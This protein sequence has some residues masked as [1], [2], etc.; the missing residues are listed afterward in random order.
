[1]SLIDEFALSDAQK[2]LW[3]AQSLDAFGTAYRV[4][5][6][7]TI[8]GPMDR[9]RLAGALLALVQRHEV[10]R[11][12]FALTAG[13]PVQRIQAKANPAIE[14]V[15]LPG[16]WALGLFIAD[17]LA[18]PMDPAH[19]T[20]RCVIARCAPEY[21][22][23][24]LDLHHLICDGVSVGIL[25][26]E[27]Q[28]LYQGCT[29]PEVDYQYVDWS[30]WKASTPEDTEALVFWRERLAKLPPPAPLF[31]GA[32]GDVNRAHTILAHLPPSVW[33]GV[34]QAAQALNVTSFEWLLSV[35]ASYLSAA[36]GVSPLAV[37]VPWFNRER[38]EFQNTVGCF[39]DTAI[40]SLSPAT[41]LTFAQ[42]LPSLADGVRDHLT[43]AAV[44]W[45]K[46]NALWRDAWP[47]ALESPQPR[48]LF[49]LQ[50][51][52]PALDR[53]PGLT[54]SV[55][56]PDNG[57]AKYDLVV[58]VDL[59]PADGGAAQVRLE[60][61]E[62]ALDSTQAADILADLRAWWLC[63]SHDPQQTV[64]ELPRLWRPAPLGKQ[65]NSQNGDEQGLDAW[66][67]D[68][69][70]AST[71]LIQELCTHWALTLVLERAGPDDNFFSLGGDSILVLRLVS[72]L[73]EQGLRVKPRDV[74]QHPTPRTLALARLQSI[75]ATYSHP[76]TPSI[77]SDELLPLE[78]WFFSLGLHNPNHWNQALALRLPKGLNPEV[79]HAALRQ[80]H[81]AHQGFGLRWERYCDRGWRLSN[82]EAGRDF[83]LTSM[84]GDLSGAESAQA[85]HERLHLGQGPLSALNWCVT[86]GKLTWMVHH[87]AVDAVSWA[88]LVKQLDNALQQS[89][90]LPP[91]APDSSRNAR[92]QAA[93]LAEVREPQADWSQDHRGLAQLPGEPCRYADQQKCSLSLGTEFL[94]QAHALT[95]CG[96]TLE[97]ILLTA[98]ARLLGRESA[99]TE[100][101]IALEHHGRDADSDNAASEVGWFTALAPLHLVWSREASALDIL[102]DI[103]PALARW[104]R[105]ASAWLPWAQA[106]PG[107]RPQ[108]PSLSFN[109][110]GRIDGNSA[111]G[112]AIEPL[113]DL[114]L[115][116][117]EGQRPF[118][119]ELLCWRSGTDIHLTWLAPAT[120]PAAQVRAW[121]HHIRE[122]ATSLV[123]IG[124]TQ[125]FRL[126]AG[127]L[128]PGLLYHH[129]DDRQAETAYTEQVSAWLD[130]T[131]HHG[132]L[133]TAWAHCV[134]RHEALRTAFRFSADGV[135]RRVIQPTATL[136]FKIIDLRGSGLQA[137]TLF[138]QACEQERR[139][140]F[141]I[142][143]PPLGRVLLARF[144]DTRSQLA[145]T[146]H[147]AVLDGWSLPV[148]LEDLIAFHD[149]Q[150][151]LSS[152]ARPLACLAI[153]R[154]HSAVDDASLHAEWRKILAQATDRG[155]L[156]LRS[157]TIE[158]DLDLDLLLD[159]ALS[160]RIASRAADHGVST[161]TWY[162]SAWA[163]TLQVLGLG[164]TPIFGL[165]VS[166][167]QTELHGIERHVGLTV[168]TLPLV[169][170]IHPEQP[171][172]ALLEQVQARSAFL[173]ASAHM[174][175]S[176]VHRLAGA[177]GE[178]LFES[179][180][181]FENY[182]SGQMAGRDFTVGQ[183]RM[184]EQAHY[185]L[186]LAVLPGASTTLRLALR[187]GRVAASTGQ[188]ILAGMRSVL[189][190]SS[191]RPESPCVQLRFH[192]AVNL[193]ALLAAAR[194][195][196]SATSQGT[197]YALLARANA[198]WPDE[199]AVQFD[200]LTWNYR[201]LDKQARS[202]A[203]GLQALGLQPGQ[204]VAFA[205]ARS[206]AW[207]AGVYGASFAGLAFVCIDPALPA[208]R[209]A[210][211]IRRS[212]AAL[213]VVD[214]GQPDEPASG[215]T[216]T[217]LDG[218]SQ[219][220]QDT[221]N[222]VETIPDSLAY[223]VYTSGSTGRPKVVGVPQRGLH[224]LASAQASQAQLSV[225][226]RVYQFASPSFDAV[227]AEICMTAW[228]GA[229]LCMPYQGLPIAQIDFAADLARTRPTHITLP[230]SLA[231]SLEPGDFPG[232]RVMLVAGE[233]GS[234]S[235]LR[236]IRDA[237]CL[238]INAYGPSEASV[239]ATMSHW[240]DDHD[241][242]LGNAIQG[243]EVLVLDAMGQACPQGVTG[244]LAIGG[245]G[246]AWGY[247][248]DPARTAAAFVPH[249]FPRVPG[250]RLYLS[251]D[252]GLRDTSNQ[253]VFLGR[254]DRQVKLRGQRI[255]LGEIEACLGSLPGV[256]AARV[257][258]R[259]HETAARLCAWLQPHG[260]HALSLALC[261]EAVSDRLPVAMVPHAWALIESW[262]LTAL[263]KVDATRLAD[264]EPLQRVA[265]G[266]WTKSV[267]DTALLT[268]IVSIWCD[269]LGPHVHADMDFHQASG[270]SISA[271]RVAARLATL[272][273]SIKA[274]DLLGGLTPRR[275]AAMAATTSRYEPAP[276]Q[277]AWSPIQT[278]LM[279][280][281]QRQLPRW[282]LSVD[283]SLHTCI[284]SVK[285]AAVIHQV[286]I[287]HDALRLVCDV[288]S[289]VLR[290]DDAA[291]PLIL[292]THL[293]TADELFQ[294]L[295]AD[296]EARS[297]QGLAAAV[298]DGPQPRLQ[299]VVHHLWMDV[300][301]L[302]LLVDEISEQFLST[303][304]TRPPAPSFLTWAEALQ[305]QSQA[306]HF[307]SELD[308][309]L[310][311]LASPLPWTIL[312][313]ASP[314]TEAQVSRTQVEV[315]LPQ[316]IPPDR[317][318]EAVL[319]Q[320]LAQCVA[321]PNT[322]LLVEC[323]SHGRD[324]LQSHDVS[325]TLG[326]FTA[327]YPLRL[328]S[329]E[330][331][332]AQAEA[333]A[334]QLAALPAGGA[335][336]SA[337]HRWR[338]H[339]PGAEGLAIFDDCCALSFNYLGAI[340]RAPDGHDI[341]PLGQLN[342]GEQNQVDVD[343]G[344]RRIRPIALEAWRSA[345]QLTLRWTYQ[346]TQ[347][348]QADTT[349]A[350]VNLALLE[351]IKP[352]ASEAINAAV[353]AK[354]SD[355]DDDELCDL[356]N[357]LNG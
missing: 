186:A 19:V 204:C 239:C 320:S 160:E 245:V 228:A 61:R 166:G 289:E 150:L 269:A 1:M 90:A 295:R 101:H 67:T 355:L 347:W 351:L 163:L 263:G 59:D 32:A 249:P 356:M 86:T 278:R 13:G 287:R 103:V 211:M 294:R 305:T 243:V 31:A 23:L 194:G 212:N 83:V 50:T 77:T 193:G 40:L 230:P 132:R 129:A 222:P 119:H 338:A 324:A 341:H 297:F 342:L 217:P 22:L 58:R 141:D 304:V 4:P 54:L 76:I 190:L 145:F 84:H 264:P 241:P 210:D 199:T 126:P 10:L 208:Q 318:L 300:V 33:L 104:R 309:W 312:V 154:A 191:W 270:D 244:E 113:P 205:C 11:T 178:A 15:D 91:A 49:V 21:H 337:L 71:T 344:L 110:L 51:Q 80:V 252:R 285:L 105:T 296:L 68:L 55:D 348:P 207:L 2:A 322:S 102:S 148:L 157:T 165:T 256:L 26:T 3:S 70:A 85:L 107:A 89:T 73:R 81:T 238:V 335:G 321:Q 153:V 203:S 353:T 334:R 66:G 168:N 172:A 192:T 232:L 159:S 27:L 326:W 131:V 30:E 303:A 16:E 250:E 185:P 136:P 282:L 311:V 298:W 60:Y 225:G 120:V 328:E 310:G 240:L 155:E 94:E 234:A 169:L 189:S 260:G 98:L 125:G 24:Y 247:L 284:D 137:D 229:S 156:A 218:L 273:L 216:V 151:H 97:E 5:L 261:A 226:D 314:P 313:S 306:G 116:D 167:R 268:A 123:H 196:Q 170:N 162:L 147:H 301:S 220:G 118:A 267:V 200:F 88:I 175:L 115:H 42:Q 354:A 215:L 99:T 135:L 17:Q 272:G 134:Q 223:V 184:R 340:D 253:L 197:L 28:S 6:T 271:M 209:R 277:A 213:L 87:L 34:R 266:L 352:S 139:A 127:P 177:P 293:G 235:Q 44:G 140:G 345:R 180:F 274:R 114:P 64:T 329:S 106:A 74:F 143:Q 281:W 56:A 246:L 339:L 45:S 219:H 206:A 130:G 288:S 29:L 349:I 65:I 12:T 36:A 265:Q 171:F 292:R 62:T 142:E 357:A 152:Q 346:R 128:A 214:A 317:W 233:R 9:E 173:Q 315:T 307:D 75:A 93:R 41:D 179:L 332:L 25:A 323:E 343:P 176:D 257:E 237:G 43:H 299:I 276:A 325:T 202:M 63:L 108:L 72:Q 161:T 236:A 57:G 231:A 279:N 227:V 38:E 149:A 124:A 336:F 333:L 144:S 112:L 254:K 96:F 82:S 286:A 92:L 109:Y 138:E 37:A 20:L 195:P 255:E 122:E 280:H 164:R 78:R 35:L 221:A 183:V 174:G 48:V 327:Y 187:N 117:P 290:R 8:R 242:A 316:N 121:L 302:R 330:D 224:N 275:L 251:G 46:L 14:Q 262:P 181:V 133:R 39:V 100:A 95:D 146:H 53:I 319:L 308:L 198:L 111:H 158:P 291:L 52:L 69:S 18:R 201:E 47:G 248:G 331:A 259:G 188:A 350:A 7:L 258:L 283:I 79:L 182:P